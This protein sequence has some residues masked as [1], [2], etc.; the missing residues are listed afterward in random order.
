MSHFLS[1]KIFIND[2]TEWFESK[3]DFSIVEFCLQNNF[4]IQF[5]DDP[6][7]YNKPIRSLLFRI[8]DNFFV[9]YCEYFLEPIIYTNDGTP[10]LESIKE[11]LDKLQNLIGKIFEFDF[12]EK[13]ELRFSYGEAEECD[14]ETVKASTSQV[15]KVIL[16]E[17]LSDYYF[18]TIKVIIENE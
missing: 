15:K 1:G 12:V 4:A 18:P 9:D 17:Y 10:I 16:K 7:Y 14:Y 13:V 8:S 2:T 3:I 5:Y 6:K 11:D